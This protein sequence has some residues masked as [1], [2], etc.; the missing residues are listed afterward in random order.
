MISEELMEI[1]HLSKDTT[2]AIANP[3]A[4]DWVCMR[5]TLLPSMLLSVKQNLSSEQDLKLFE[6]SMIYAYRNGNIPREQS[7]LIVA[8]SGSRYRKIKGIAEAVFSLFGIDFP[9]AAD[10]AA[11]YYNPSRSLRL[12][13]FGQLG[14][15][16]HTLLTKLGIAKP[17]TILELS[18]DQLVRQARTTKQYVPIPKHPA[19]YE[20]LAFVVPEKTYVSPVIAFLKTLDPLIKDVTL[21]DSYNT[22]RTFHV[23]YQSDRKNLT[24]DDISKIREKIISKMKKEFNATLKTA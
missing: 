10:H 4:V 17:V 1:F 3:L 23:T 20:D 7:T 11:S 19:S 5:P 8:V 14:E 2:Y 22:I 9:P 18:V 13:N 6:L 12:G 16:E 24:S 15:V 21:F